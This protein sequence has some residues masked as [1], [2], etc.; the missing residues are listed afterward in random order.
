MRKFLVLH[1]K[2]DI[3][4]RTTIVACCLVLS[5]SSNYNKSRHKKPQLVILLPVLWCVLVF[6]FAKELSHFFSWKS[7]SVEWY[8][9]CLLLHIWWLT[10]LSLDYS[11]FTIWQHVLQQHETHVWWGWGNNC[12]I[13]LSSFI[14]CDDDIKCNFCTAHQNLIV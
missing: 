5:V 13:Y 8:S 10:C 11:N 7:S 12:L 6:Y 3:W 4:G 14:S 2:N 1:V 9:S